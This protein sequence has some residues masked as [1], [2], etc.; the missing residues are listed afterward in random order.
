MSISVKSGLRSG[1]RVET[2]EI[3]K[4]KRELW[5]FCLKTGLT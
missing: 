1:F 2:E 5:D 3:T 4:A